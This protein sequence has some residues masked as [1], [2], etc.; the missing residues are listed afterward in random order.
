MP[1]FD[2]AGY[3]IWRCDFKYNEE[4]KKVFMSSNQIGGF[5]STFSPFTILDQSLINVI[6]SS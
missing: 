2:K 1:R 5:F 3:S 4:L 6:R